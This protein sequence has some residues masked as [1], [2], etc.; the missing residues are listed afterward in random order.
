[1]DHLMNWYWGVLE[2]PHP[3]RISL[4]SR[5]G[6]FP[7]THHEV[8]D[9]LDLWFRLTDDMAMALSVIPVVME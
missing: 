7:G 9:I 1:M 3:D 6:S 5:H 2:N 4:Y 8:Q